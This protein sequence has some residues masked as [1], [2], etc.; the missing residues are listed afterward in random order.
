MNF[1]TSIQNCKKHHSPWWYITMEDALT[2]EQIV[3]IKN[4]NIEIEGKLNDGTRSGYKEGVEKQNH[5]FREYVTKE[6]SHRYP[7]LTKLIKE[8]QSQEVRELIFN[9]V[10][11]PYEDMAQPKNFEGCYVR[12]EVLNDPKGFWLK[13]HLD[14]EEK[15]ISSLIYVNDTDEDLNLGT[16][17]YNEELELMSTVPFKHN[18]GYIFS[19][20]AGKGKWHGMEKGKIVKKERRGIQLNYVTF[21]TDWPV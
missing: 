4:A 13:P 16:D 21:R 12:L 1:L 9:K 14:I 15:L 6:N 18:F 3:E 11:A 20:H 5:K 8:L 2:D 7:E 17:L 19:E 10:F